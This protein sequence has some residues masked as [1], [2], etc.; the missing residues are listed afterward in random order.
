MDLVSPAVVNI[1]NPVG[2]WLEKDLMRVVSIVECE[3]PEPSSDTE[4]LLVFP[5]TNFIVGVLVDVADSEN[6][7]IQTNVKRL[8]EGEIRGER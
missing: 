2:L 5:K 6:V 3:P 4:I 1:Q 8:T 7:V